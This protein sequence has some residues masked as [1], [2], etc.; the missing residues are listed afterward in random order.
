MAERS[1]GRQIVKRSSGPA[2]IELMTSLDGVDPTERLAGLTMPV[3]VL[4]GRRDAIVP[5]EASYQLASLLP[6]VELIV[7]EDAGHVPTVTRPAWV[8]ERISEWMARRTPA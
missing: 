3:L 6:D 2:A 5:I 7:A 8:A 1:W 4:H